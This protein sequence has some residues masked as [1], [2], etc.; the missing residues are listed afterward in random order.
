LVFGILLTFFS[1]FGQT[2]LL[3]VYI[4]ELIREFKLSPGFFST[5]YASATLCSGLTLIFAGRI[6]DRVPLKKFTL[7]VI[8]G[9]FCANI[10]AGF[11]LN[12]IMLFLAIFMLRF[13]GQGLL[14][15]TS[16][17]AMGRY[18]S[19]ARGK[20]LSIA[21]LGYPL[22]ETLMP[23][24]A[25]TAIM[26]FGWRESFIISAF[27]SIGLFL[28]LVIFLLRNFDKKKIKEDIS[29]STVPNIPLSTELHKHWSQKQIIRNN[30]FYIFAPTIFIMGFV[31]TALFFFQTFIA[32]FKGWSL[33]WMTLNITA[34]AV[35]S[36]VCSILAGPL[37]DRFSAIRLFPTILIPM[38]L[39]LMVLGLFDHPATATAFWFLVGISGGMNPTISNALYAETY[40]TKNLGSV[41]SV[42]S[43]VMIIST[44][45]G[46]VLYSFL[47]ENNFNFNHIHLLLSAAIT[48][49]IVMV[50]FAVKYLR[51]KSTQL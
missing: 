35:S 33:E 15:H 40:G 41:R 34:Y 24:A 36:S 18:F 38:V 27:I 46:P 30:R 37:T 49:N 48:L 17:T 2:F 19:K 5:L 3:S 31:Q 4:P 26:V 7:W 45:V 25:L 43:F 44:A 13:F 47:L 8:V 6:I 10:V 23:I 9:I 51:K 1:G 39:G 12:L 11:T 29:R 21:V 14:S 22:S 28:P 32:D 50:F 42:F 16:M 20:A